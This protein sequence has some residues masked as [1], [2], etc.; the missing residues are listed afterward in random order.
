MEAQRGT[1]PGKGRKKGD[2][3]RVER[4]ALPAT[5]GQERG[6]YGT[7][8]PQPS[9]VLAEAAPVHQDT[10]GGCD[11]T[12]VGVSGA[13][14]GGFAAVWQ[15][16]REG[17]IGIFLGL[18]EPD[19]ERGELQVSISDQEGTAR[20]LTPAIALLHEGHG[21][22]AWMKMAGRP[23]AMLRFFAPDRERWSGL[24]PLASPAYR[25]VM[26]DAAKLAAEGGPTPAAV[27]RQQRGPG[28]ARKHGWPTMPTVAVAPDGRVLATWLES[29]RVY[30][31]SFKNR[32][33][34]TPAIRLNASGVLATGPASIAPAQDGR[35]LVA[36]Q[37]AD[38]IDVA[39]FGEKP[40]PE[41]GVG[42]E[43]R[44]LRLRDDP[45]GGWWLLVQ[46]E[47]GL[48][49]RHLGDAG[50]PDR[51]DVPLALG[52]VASADLATWSR[53]LVV[54]IETNEV[55]EGGDPERAIE[56]RFLDGAG[57]RSTATPLRR[58][59]S[60]RARGAFL[61]G[62][63]P[64]PERVLL[65][66]N[67]DNG[68]NV[69]VLYG[70]VTME[71][72]DPVL[73]EPRTWNDDVASA[74][75]KGVAVD[76]NGE[77][78]VIAWSDERATKGRIYTRRLRADGTWVEDE[79]LA[80]GDED[81]ADRDRSMQR[82]TVAM[83]PDGRYLV[84][85]K[86]TAG[87]REPWRLRARVFAADGTPLGAAFDVDPGQGTSM[88]WAPAAVALGQGQGY[89]VCWIRTGVGPIARRV[90]L[91]G[92]L[93]GPAWRLSD[94][95][96]DSA[97]NP[98][99]VQLAD[100][101]FVCVWDEQA[102]AKSRVLTGRKIGRDAKPAG[103]PILFDFG[104]A[105]GEL[106]AELAPTDDGGFLMAWT[107]RDSPGRDVVARFFQADGRPA[108][109]PLGMSTQKNEQ[110]FCDVLRLPDGTWV[111]AWE[112][113]LSGVDHV[114]ARRI[115][116]DKKTVGPTVMLDPWLAESID[117]RHAP[118]LAVLGD[119]FAALWS[120]QAR[121]KGQDV[122]LRRFGAEFDAS[123]KPPPTEER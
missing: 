60:H 92:E 90:S 112:D 33:A 51:D 77:V 29:G 95:T 53:G 66:W 36:W 25:K 83:N 13:P 43:G 106:D 2:K 40:V 108:G 59:A 3:N 55:A 61:A 87:G 121:A 17:H 34:E 54:C 5:H 73:S 10:T 44:L 46:A 19:G 62:E 93:I 80:S 91:S 114:V 74:Y 64:L 118:R 9:D 111:V 85:W 102:N 117:V 11:Q 96:K 42:G 48:V 22:F 57:L 35:L 18:I 49:L 69:D 20:E 122:V 94:R 105:G 27:A 52:R 116:A 104:G 47:S 4:P 30:L 103:N 84:A 6:E 107:T 110:D 58:T 31:Q 23:Q 101:T 115:H 15:D 109:P 120:D 37:A 119:G 16:T 78:A 39:T 14:Q 26:R 123:P 86:E 12:L 75:Q 8:Y 89:L 21:A 38:G 113:D 28:A 65:A 70:L 97:A 68:A 1:G 67:D 88:N 56:L 50:K 99:V 81:A 72:D 71:G 79:V 98:A 76:S 45:H 41:R 63:G 100:R 7:I 82:C 24:L 32:Y